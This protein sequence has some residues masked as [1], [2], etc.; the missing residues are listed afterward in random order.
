VAKLDITPLPPYFP[1]LVDGPSKQSF[2]VT[3]PRTAT[4]NEG[5]REASASF[6]TVPFSPVFDSFP[7]LTTHSSLLPLSLSAKRNPIV[8]PPFLR[9]QSKAVPLSCVPV[10]PSPKD[11]FFSAFKRRYPPG[12]QPRTVNNIGLAPPCHYRHGFFLTYPPLPG[13]FWLFQGNP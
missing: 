1:V 5:E 6:L 13:L 10:F 11:P 7:L 9:P 8:T 3:W 12:F 4:S 2:L